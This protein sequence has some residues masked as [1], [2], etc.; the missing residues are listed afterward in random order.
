[1]LVRIND[2]DTHFTLS[3]EGRPVVLLHGWGTSGE[4]LGGIAKALEDQFLEYVI[5]LPG[6]GWTPPPPAVWGTRDY[7]SHVDAFMD[8]TRIPSA[9]VLGHSFGGRIALALAAH[10]PHRVR[11][12]I[13]VASAGIRPRRGLGYSLRVAGAKLGKRLFS[14]PMWGRLGDRI[15]FAISQRVGSRDYLN[16]GRMQATLV[17][18]VNEDLRG[19][20]PSIRVPTLIIW[21]DRDQEVPRSSMEIM[22][23]GIK[24]SRLEVMEGA[25]HFPFIDRSEAFGRMVR[26]FLC[27]DRK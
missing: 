16:A 25:G 11:H 2:L 6:F 21:G 27:Q 24:D 8:S 3:G 18:V 13:L 7:A 19:I 14:S 17:K 9:S 4:S 10:S 15:L 20:L 1:M 26:D 22:A 12:L 5:D 23:Q